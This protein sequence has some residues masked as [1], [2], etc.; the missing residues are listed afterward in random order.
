MLLDIRNFAQNQHERQNLLNQEVTLAFKQLCKTIEDVPTTEFDKF[1]NPKLKKEIEDYYRD[2][3]YYH[4]H[5]T[6]NKPKATL[7]IDITKESLIGIYEKVNDNTSA[8]AYRDARR[9]AENVIYSMDIANE[10]IIDELTKR[11]S[12]YLKSADENF[13][14]KT[15]NQIKFDDRSR[16]LMVIQYPTTELP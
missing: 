6:Y 1:F 5:A 11:L 15:G 10:I 8:I 13:I 4:Q 9:K 2:I 16:Y 7:E 3:E 12:D 14:I